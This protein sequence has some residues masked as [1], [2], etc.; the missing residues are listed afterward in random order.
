[1]LAVIGMLAMLLLAARMWQILAAIAL[2]AFV[3]WVGLKLW[4]GIDRRLKIS[5]KI[6]DLREGLKPIR[7]PLKRILI[8]IFAPISVLFFLYNF[9]NAILIAV[10]IGGVWGIRCIWQRFGKRWTQSKA[11]KPLRDLPIQAAYV[12][13]VVVALLCATVICSFVQEVT[14]WKIS[15]INAQY[16]Y[17]SQYYTL[18][19]ESVARLQS[20]DDEAALYHYVIVNAQN[21]LVQEFTVDADMYYVEYG[22][23]P[24]I[25]EG[26][27]MEM[28][29]GSVNV[30]AVRPYLTES[31]RALR[32]FLRVVA[33]ASIPLIYVGAIVIC[34]MIFYQRKLRRPI[35]ILNSAAEK[36][37]QSDLDFHVEYAPR[38]EMGRLCDSFEKMRAALQNSNREMWRNMEERRRLNA[39]FSHDLR[40]PL[41]V[42]KGHVELLRS[43]LPDESVEREEMLQEVAA[44]SKHIGRL[45]NYVAAMSRL[46]RLEDLEIHAS[47][48]SADVFARSMRE[49]AEILGKNK[50]V[51]FISSP[52]SYWHIDSEVVMQV[53]EN[54]MSN[55]VRYARTQVMVKLVTDGKA[56]ELTVS[57]DGK[58]FSPQ[59]LQKATEPFYRSESSA[60]VH[61]GL[62]LNICRVLCERHGGTIL[63]RNSLTGGGEVRARFAFHNE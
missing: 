10:C 53:F 41:T 63:V 17:R 19:M 45:E 3:I 8:F 49:S 20:V 40:T 42:L 46:Q 57:D 44:M 50:K 21:E 23:D 39:A 43:G 14:S 61:L 32:T 7:R 62:G 35:E 51:T 9:Q 34:A 29:G 33:L 4:R 18:P 47:A 5:E 6:A 37:A 15:E 25:A 55:A 52:G 60:S 16:D 28:T 26:A 54:L 48:V 11:A 58:G 27:N 36:I 38:D 22:Y 1:M 56:L 59:D 30:I 12:L 2:I 31:D 13:Y 24:M